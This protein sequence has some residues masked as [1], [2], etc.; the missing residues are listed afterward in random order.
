MT[1]GVIPP[2]TWTTR[3]A[4]HDF[5]LVLYAANG[6]LPIV[7]CLRW[8][9]VPAGIVGIVA[10][11]IPLWAAHRVARPSGESSSQ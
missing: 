2:S 1:L 6:L 5:P 4:P 10:M 7:I 3:V 9:M 8:G 11:G